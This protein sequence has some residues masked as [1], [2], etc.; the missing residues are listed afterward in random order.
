MAPRARDIYRSPS[1]ADLRRDRAEDEKLIAEVPAL[2]RRP[3][4]PTPRREWA[5]EGDLVECGPGSRGVVLKVRDPGSVPYATVRWA[6]GSTGR[7]TIS[8]LRKVAL[9]ELSGAD[10]A[11]LGLEV[12]S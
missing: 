2:A 6:S 12:S 3:F 4:A 1:A 7:H 9:G 8:T 11:A 5:R 10:R